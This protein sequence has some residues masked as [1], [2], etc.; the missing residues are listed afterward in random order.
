MNFWVQWN[1]GNFLT[2]W[3]LVSS[4]RR[5]LPSHR[6]SQLH[7]EIKTIQ[8]TKRND[9]RVGKHVPA[10]F[11]SIFFMYLGNVAEQVT[12]NTHWSIWILFIAVRISICKHYPHFSAASCP[13][14]YFSKW[15]LWAVLPYISWELDTIPDWSFWAYFFS[16]SNTYIL[17]CILLS[18]SGCSVSFTLECSEIL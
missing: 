18:T 11:S 12:V 13:D 7:K 2:G 5:T 17:I 9:G 3:T 15:T 16:H 14:P 6:F 8:C 4:S 1:V 10:H